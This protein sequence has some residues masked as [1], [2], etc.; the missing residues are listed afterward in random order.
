ML[1][2]TIIDYIISLTHLYGLVHKDK[3]VEIFNLQNRERVNITILSGIM[4]N[5][6]DDLRKN[7]V[8]IY[9][10][11]FVH[12]TIMEFD[13]FD[14][15]LRKRSGKPHYIPARKELLKYKDGTYF[16][17]T[18]EYR[19]LL[20]YAIKNIFD[21]DEYAA[22]MLCE[23]VQ[24]ICQFD[25]SVPEIFEVFNTRG[26][27]FKSE[28]QINEIMPLVMELANNTRI[29]ENNGHTPQEIFEKYEKPHLRPLPDKPFEFGG[30][31]IID[32]KSGRKIGRNDPCPCGSGKKYKKCCLGKGG[33]S[34]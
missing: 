16:E 15:Q 20:R 27:D 34:K 28:K 7:F 2:E 24:G 25:Y 14:E 31:D 32:F 26:V 1:N 19:A 22:E 5:T 29:W 13:D 33:E 8:E 4:E 18:K 10:D 17:V 30:A 12:E 3:V 21:G 6:P 11:Y 23:D 9:G